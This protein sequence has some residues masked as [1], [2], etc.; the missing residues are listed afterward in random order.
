MQFEQPSYE[1]WRCPP[2]DEVVSFLARC[3]REAYQSHP[4]DT[5]D[6]DLALL[7]QIVKPDRAVRLHE[8]MLRENPAPDR[9]VDL[10]LQ[11]CAEDPPHTS[12]LEHL[13]ITV[14]FRIDRGL[15]H[16]LVRHRV[17]VVFTQ[18]S[19]RYCNYAG[20]RLGGEIA[21]AATGPGLGEGVRTDALRAAEQAYQDL[22]Q[23]GVAP[24]LARDVLPTALMASLVMTG[25]LQAWRYVL[26]MRT[27]PRAHPRLRSLM[28]RLLEDLRGRVPVVFESLWP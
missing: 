28:L 23:R 2:A 5:P 13:S 7:R 10:V 6:A 15:T 14:R 1:I 22:V 9:V 17:G 12:V 25:N 8:R 16:E 24:Q 3:A 19:T 20:R 11:D 18:E 4:R 27:G 21:C 26:R